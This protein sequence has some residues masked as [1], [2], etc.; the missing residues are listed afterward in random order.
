MAPMQHLKNLVS[1]KRVKTTSSPPYLL[2]LRSSNTF[3]IGTICVAVFTDLFLYG[4][5][6]P[7]IPR[8]LEERAGVP[9]KDVQKWVSILLAVYGGALLVGSP[10]SGWWADRSSSRRLPLLLGL[11]AL[12]GSTVM[13][14][15]ARTIVL[16]I[17]GRVL[18]G[19]AA[20]VVWTVGTA[21]LVDTVGQNS[22]GEVLGWTS[23]SMAVAILLAP[24]LGGLVY[25]R[26]GYYSVYYMSFSLIALDIVLRVFLVE[27]KI[28]RKWTVTQPAVSESA[29][30]VGE[31]TDSTQE[32]D[33]E[34]HENSRVPVI[35]NTNNSPIPEDEP[36]PRSRGL[37]PVFTLLASRRLLIALWGCIV[38]GSLMTAFDSVVPLFVMETFGWNSTGAGVVFLC[39]TIP[40]FASP[41]IGHLADT[42]GPRWLSVLGFLIVI[43]FWIL[44]RLVTHNT[45]GQ[46]ALFCV[47]L[48]LIGV[49]LCLVMPPLMAEITYVVE[50]K[51][52]ERPGR[53]GATGAYAQAYGLFI[54]AF[55]AGSLIG[56]V[57]AGYVNNA[58]GWGTMSWSLAV[59]SFFGAVPCLFYTG[60]DLWAEN[61]K[62][63]RERPVGRPVSVEGIE[64][65]RVGS[66]N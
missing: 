8:A 10:L 12:G 24:L 11:F 30:A 41:Y 26:A 7:V 13:L 22:I 43:P 29:L 63:G 27:K 36:I 42:H 66:T 2:S 61:A 50:A 32:K 14:C 51:E 53:F 23:V 64:E 16:F 49:G 9:Q 57:W 47:L 21:L 52:K 38:Q 15:L 48:T 40:S 20:A 34:V 60:G 25:E 45:L 35:T 17:M 59:F 37:P 19:F 6:V 44:L 5:I 31:T 56:P 4:I 28:A 18:Q 1:D 65:A 54:A 62:T 58:A 46:K 39:I 3:I 33:H 55:A